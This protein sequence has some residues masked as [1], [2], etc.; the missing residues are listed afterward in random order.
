[1]KRWFVLGLVVLAL[2]VPALAGN[3]DFTARVYI[4]QEWWRQESLLQLLNETDVVYVETFQYLDAVMGEEQLNKIAALGLK[5]EILPPPPP[6]LMMNFGFYLKYAQVRD[7]LRVYASRYPTICRFDSAGPMHDTTP[8]YQYYL[9]IANP[10]TG[11]TK[12]A[13]YFNGVTH[14]R[15]PMGQEVTRR[16]ALWLL[17]NYNRDS[18]ATWLVN[19]RQFI[20]LPVVNP[21]GYV[22]N[23]TYSDV[24]G[25]RKNRHFISGGDWTVDVNRNFGY[26]WGYD[27][28]GSSGNRGDETY[29]G[30]SRFSELEAQKCRDLFM[31]YKFRSGCDY[32]TYGS[33]NLCPYGYANVVPADM[34]IFQEILDTVRTYNQYTT[35]R[36][37]RIY[38]V[39]Y[40]A[41]GG[42]IDWE[43]ADTLEGGQQKFIEFALS[44]ELNPANSSF[45][46]GNTDSTLIRQ[47]FARTFPGQLYQSKIA[48]VYFFRRNLYVD[49]STTSNGNRTGRLDPGEIANLWMTVRNH[50]VSRVDSAVSITAVLRSLDTAIT[51]NTP[52]GSFGKIL[53]VS[54]GDNRTAKFQ[55][56]CSRGAPQGSWKKFRVE[57]TSWDDGN[58]IMQPLVDSVQIGN[59]P[60]AVE[61]LPN[62][63]ELVPFA[64]HPVQP[65]PMAI[66]G[67]V[68]F[69]L[70]KGGEVSLV[71]YNALGQTV[72]TLANGQYPAGHQ[73]TVWDGRDEAGRAVA[74]GAYFLRLRSESQEA[75]GR[76]VVVR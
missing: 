60:V 34:T 41:N 74:P 7:S 4:P 45:W 71:V 29:R 47:E 14:A 2:A 46:W 70:L 76:V 36:T 9:K 68:R 73:T 15:E 66:S 38:A 61:E 28:N 53:R 17:Q 49:D 63:D 18:L 23:E 64:L 52:N 67:T 40:A 42:S 39:L 58:T 43:Y 50:A 75:L 20:M 54:T 33:Y 8:R 30:P 62:P 16:Y 1:M 26:K 25:W 56:R 37:G 44:L 55:V 13:A 69:S 48:G 22:Y 51:V 24:Y 72:R 59:T 57:M 10:L 27:N 12:P 35:G 65:N 32:H 21:D 11:N 3:R 6:E 31:Q 5:T 19:N